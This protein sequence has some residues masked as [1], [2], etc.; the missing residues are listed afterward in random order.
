MELVERVEL[1]F[2]SILLAVDLPGKSS[3]LPGS[4]HVPSHELVVPAFLVGLTVK[5]VVP[6]ATGVG[7]L[8][9]HVF[10][11]LGLSTVVVE[12]TL[13][14]RAI[15]EDINSTTRG[16]SVLEVADINAAVRLVHST[17]SMRFMS[18]L[19]IRMR[20]LVELADIHV[21]AETFGGRIGLSIE[22][23][24]KES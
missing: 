2:V 16:P 13:V 3:L 20:Y 8:V 12:V 7:Q 24:I 19:G 1:A 15:F 17:E 9:R 10:S 22:F 14:V 23:V 6:E 5:G 4:V 18:S 11:F 21:F